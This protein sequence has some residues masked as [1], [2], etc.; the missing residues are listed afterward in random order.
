MKTPPTLTTCCSIIALSILA[1]GTHAQ[2]DKE[3]IKVK[4]DKIV[5]KT[6][7]GKAKIDKDGNVIKMKGPDGAQAL[8]KARAELGEE[9]AEEF[10]RSLASGYTIPRERYVYLDPVPE[11][12]LEMIPNR[13]SGVEYRILGDTIYA[14]NPDTYTVVDVI[15]TSSL[16]GAT[17]TTTSTTTVEVPANFK[18]SLTVG[19]TIPRNYYS[20]F[21][22]VPEQI[23][24]RLS[25]APAN[26]EYRYYD[27]T[28]YSINP[29]NY[30]ILDI[31]S[32]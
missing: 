5:V 19:Y 24:T 6:D 29:N 27:G 30:T 10:R 13:R 26:V 21:E 8:A 12:Y 1:L 25:A 17:T 20:Y 14:V 15:Q 3:K 11:T 28:V 4:D 18:E 31:I 22:D 9:Q 23:R 2:D 16:A 7:E 32:Y